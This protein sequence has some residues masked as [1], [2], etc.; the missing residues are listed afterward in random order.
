MSRTGRM[1][2]SVL[3]GLG[4]LP[5]LAGAAPPEG[6]QLAMTGGGWLLAADGSQVNL[7]LALPC[8]PSQPGENFTVRTPAGTFHANEVVERNCV[9][10]P[11]LREEGGSYTGSAI[12]RMAGEPARIDFA[13]VDSGADD[14]R[15]DFVSFEVSG[16]G[17][18]FSAAG[19]LAEGEIRMGKSFNH[20]ETLLRD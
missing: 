3:V 9:G 2:V 19:P 14:G 18:A 11:N 12:G 5:P 6:V 16:E 10:N 4:V 15:A 20:N 13:L 7:G 1:V 8:D 17:G